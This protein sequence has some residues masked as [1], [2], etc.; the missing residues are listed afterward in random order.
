MN[1]RNK[2]C[3]ANDKFDAKKIKG[4]I[5]DNFLNPLHMEFKGNREIVVEGC[6]SIEEY[7]EN[8]IK[9]KVKNMIVSFFGRNLGI[10]CLTSDSLIIFGFITS[11]EFLT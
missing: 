4:Y 6:R 2:I 10:K 11:V 5:S 3:F 9:I 1:F 7:D 8:I